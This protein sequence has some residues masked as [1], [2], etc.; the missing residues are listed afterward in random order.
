LH[1]TENYLNKLITSIFHFIGNVLLFKDLQR[2]LKY[3]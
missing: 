1:G 3:F 2:V